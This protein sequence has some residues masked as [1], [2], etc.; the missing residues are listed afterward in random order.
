MNFQIKALE[1]PLEMGTSFS[2]PVGMYNPG[3]K[4][5]P[6]N[7]SLDFMGGEMFNGPVTVPMPSLKPKETIEFNL[8]FQA[9]YQGGINYGSWMMCAKGDS[10]LVFGDPIWIIVNVNQSTGGFQED[11]L[12]GKSEYQ[13]NDLKNYKERDNE[14]KYF[15]ENEGR[16]DE[17]YSED[18]KERYDEEYLDDVDKYFGLHNIKDDHFG[19]Q[20]YQDNSQFE[21]HYFPN[22]DSQSLGFGYLNNNTTNNQKNSNSNGYRFGQIY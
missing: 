3:D 20:D 15:E 16:Y 5:W 21:T 6:P 19:E 10:S 1:T 13:W 7:C 12:F 8:H 11:G 14:D 2:I 18:K 4:V 17:E 9:P 22:N